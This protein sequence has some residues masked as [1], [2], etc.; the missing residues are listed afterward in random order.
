MLGLGGPAAV[1]SRG[2]QKLSMIKV[3][4]PQFHWVV[5]LIRFRNQRRRETSSFGE[6]SWRLVNMLNFCWMSAILTLNPRRQNLRPGN[7]HHV[8]RVPVLTDDLSQKFNVYSPF[9]G[10]QTHLILDTRLTSWFFAGW[11]ILP[12][13]TL[14]AHASVYP[15]RL[16]TLTAVFKT[17]DRSF[18]SIL[19]A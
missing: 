11:F 18:H 8:C 1:A 10:C 2:N 9:C 7:I 17:R 14:F 6:F 5:S 15:A 13:G 3:C 12:V 16:F 4:C 19:V